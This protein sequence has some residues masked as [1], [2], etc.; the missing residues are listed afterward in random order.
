MVVS[1][2]VS[3]NELCLISIPDVNPAFCRHTPRN[4]SSIGSGG[5]FIIDWFESPKYLLIAFAKARANEVVMTKP[6]PE[7]YGG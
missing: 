5:V 4:A 6:P 1:Q 3:W 7:T 2:V